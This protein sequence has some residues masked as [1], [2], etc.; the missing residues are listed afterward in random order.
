MQADQ[1]GNGRLTGASASDARNSIDRVNAWWKTSIIDIE[2]GKIGIRGYPIEQLIGSVGFVEQIWL[3][4]TGELPAPERARLLEAVLVAGID[5]GPHAPSI[6]IARMA[7]TCGV[8]LNNAVA[9]ALNVLGDV[10]GGA[11]EQ[12]MALLQEMAEA[13]G[14]EP[15]STERVAEFFGNGQPGSGRI[16]PGFGHRFHGVDPRAVRLRSLVADA[17]R[18]GVVSGRFAALAQGV[19]AWLA[20]TKGRQIPLNIDGATALVLCELGFEPAHGRGF[21][22]LS[23]AVGILSHALEQRSEGGRIKGPMPPTTDY[24]YTGAARRDLPAGDRSSR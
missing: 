3:A 12:C 9:S 18:D 20:R 16:V 21:F 5:H 1:T 8:G 15:V 11:G 24:T 7:M 19:E 22:L 17:C 14:E 4:V 2:P 13:F 10:H 23:R 6:A